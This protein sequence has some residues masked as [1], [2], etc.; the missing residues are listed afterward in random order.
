MLNPNKELQG[1]KIVGQNGSSLQ[2]P[3]NNEWHR[4]I[5][6]S[7]CE[8]VITSAFLEQPNFEGAIHKLFYCRT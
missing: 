4:K 5:S 7:G 3:P 8:I 6:I 1:I 2:I